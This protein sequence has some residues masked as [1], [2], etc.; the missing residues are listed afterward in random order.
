MWNSV[1]ST[2]GARYITGDIESMYLQT[3]VKLKQYMH[4]PI[5]IILQEFR[6]AYDLDEKAKNSLIYMEILRGMYGL[7]EAGILANKLLR[8]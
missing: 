8:T 1:I 2:P 3:P 4:I 5:D 6:D 7:P